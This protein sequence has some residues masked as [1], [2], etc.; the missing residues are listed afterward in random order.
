MG[1]EPSHIMVVED[2]QSLAAWICDFL[3]NNGHIVTTA[4][5]GD[6]AITLIVEDDPDLVILDINLPIKNGFEVCREVRLSYDKPILM[7]TALGDESDEVRGIETGANDYLIKPVRP[8][9][10][11]ARVQSLLSSPRAVATDAEQL[12][13]FG[14]FRIDSVSRSAYIADELMDLSSNEFDVLW[15]LAKNAGI[16]LS[17][18]QLVN[19]LRGIEYDGFNRSVDLLISRLRKKLGDDSSGSTKIKTVWGKGYVF[20]A[21][22][23]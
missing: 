14:E 3:T 22:A 4:N 8:R 20:A 6:D 2:D 7:L 15:L 9:A 19:D 23:W 18:D 16:V 10:L 11:L 5:R 17:R 12:R 21:D 1:K 13:H